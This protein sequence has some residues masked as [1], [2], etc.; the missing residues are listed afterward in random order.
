MSLS[1]NRPR[2][3]AITDSFLSWLLI[4]CILP[5]MLVT[6]IEVKA[7]SS[8]PNQRFA[9]VWR[10]HGDITATGSATGAKRKLSEGDSVFV[11]ERVSAATAAETVLKTDDAGLVAI[12]PGTEFVADYFSAQGTSSDSFTMRLI[13]GSLRVITG[14]IGHTNQASNRIITPSATLGIRGTDHEPYVL[15]KDLVSTNTYRAGTY[16]KVNR[17]GTTLEALGESIDIDAGRV[18]FARS[19]NSDHG[20][21]NKV[22]AMMTLLLPVLLTKVPDFYVPGEFDAEL[23]HYSQT[24][25]KISLQQLELKRSGATPAPAAVCVPSTIAKTWLTQLDNAIIHHDAAGIIAMFAPEVA[26][27]AIVINRDGSTATIDLGRDELAQSTLTSVKQLKG[28]QHRR[29]SLDAK[30]HDPK[31]GS[32]CNW[33]DIK[34]VVIEQGRQAG[35]HFRFESQEEYVLQLRSEKW[36]AIKSETTQH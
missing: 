13:K 5:S 19:S 36:L 35:K 23:D 30:L 27:R 8:A 21:G 6:A 2:L 32:S 12:R 11:G 16:D 33:I 20:G 15:E 26:V 24:A 31:D 22:R 3:G 17:G 1:S 28:Y 10:I 18:G 7:A 9:T 29:I 34:S 25:D 4:W 14:W